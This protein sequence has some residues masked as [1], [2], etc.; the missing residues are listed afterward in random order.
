M[1]VPNEI[2]FE[3]ANLLSRESVIALRMTCRA[4]QPL[5]AFLL[6]R[7]KNHMLLFAADKT[8][9]D[10][11]R[12]ALSAGA[13]VSYTRQH[14]RVYDGVWH[15]RDTALHHAAA[16]G[17]TTIITEL[18][19]YN[20]PLDLPGKYERTPLFIAAHKG[21]EAA[22][23]LLLAAGCDP[24][25]RDRG[26]ETLLTLAIQ[27]NLTRT[28]E[29]FIHQMDGDSLGWAIRYRRLSI[30]KLMFANGIGDTFVPPLQS[31]VCSGLTYVK[32][33]IEHGELENINDVDEHGFTALA[34]AAECGHMS[35]LMY[36]LAQGADV[37][38]G[39]LE[40]RPIMSAL[41]VGRIDVIKVL[42]E[43]GAD[44]TVLRTDDVDVLT[45]ACSRGPV[46]MVEILLD[47][48]DG[49]VPTDISLVCVA[50]INNLP[51]VVRLLVERGIDVDGRGGWILDTALHRAAAFENREMVAV[52]LE[53][54]ADIELLDDKTKAVVRKLICQQI[55]AA[56]KLICQQITAARKLKREEARKDPR[57][58]GPK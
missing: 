10:L 20:P 39:P 21:H 23:D 38:T 28:A 57:W 53:C 43:H 58:R 49:W 26:T 18:L 33:C 42:L 7:F 5:Y 31:A 48:S 47:A 45:A 2:L 32:L 9:L 8:R 16:I 4:M 35:V 24:E 55:T 51:A 46:D 15:E 27:S 40:H 14:E 6:S 44:L 34:K 41:D 25:S 37:N 29:A 11:L 50:A 1:D 12:L 17:D 3:I 56:R 22:V 54:G 19:R 13:D 36:L 52:L 30:T